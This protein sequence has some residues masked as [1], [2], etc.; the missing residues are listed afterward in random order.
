MNP[1]FYPVVRFPGINF[2][3]YVNMIHYN[4]YA[5][6]LYGIQDVISIEYIII[7][8]KLIMLEC[9]KPW[10]LCIHRIFYPGNL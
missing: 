2:Y 9:D 5:S 8:D 1:C 4:L 6:I 10:I 3:T 7:N